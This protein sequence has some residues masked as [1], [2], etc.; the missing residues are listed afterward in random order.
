M[1]LRLLNPS[2]REA[3]LR[4]AQML[5]HIDGHSHEAE[6]ALLEAGRLECGAEKLPPPAQPSELTT[7]VKAFDS[8][9]EKMVLLLESCAVVAADGQTT[10]AERGEIARLCTAMGVPFSQAERCFAWVEQARAL[11]AQGLQLVAGR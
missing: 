11:Q 8:L 10:V 9:P 1:Y 6:A 5:L 2:Q 3:Y 4:V 7:V